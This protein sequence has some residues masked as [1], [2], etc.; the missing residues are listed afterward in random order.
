MANNAHIYKY[1]HKTFN[2][3]ITTTV[4]AVVKAMAITTPTTRTQ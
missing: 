1:N 2:D 3:R 4:A